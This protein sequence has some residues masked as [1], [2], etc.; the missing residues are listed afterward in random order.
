[1]VVPP[2]QPKPHA[3]QLVASPGYF[4][5]I[6]IPLL[7]GRAFTEAD[8]PHSEPVA[9]VNDLVVQTYWPG[10]NPIGK[11][12]RGWQS[13]DPWRRVVGVVR[14]IR[15]EGPEDNPEN[16][17]Y[18]PYRQI[19]WSTM[20]LVLRTH[21]PP[22]SVALDVRAA[23]QSIDPDVPA[24]EIRSM[25]DRLER[26][27]AMERIAPLLMTVFSAMAALL[28]V[29]G[30][31][32]V[33]GYWVSQRG[34]ELGIRSAVGAQRGELRWLVVRQGGALALIGLLAGLAVS[35][36]LM[37]LMRGT[38]YGVNEHDWSV[39]T[40]AVALTAAGALLAC[41]APAE[42]AARIEPAAA[43]REE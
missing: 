41:W 3:H 19:N 11:R 9:I 6:G 7:A 4:A 27:L 31:F 21:V 35:L 5:A 32:G 18:V 16:Q 33:I 34:K 13:N 39:Y 15:H 30:L 17:I 25:K 14:R 28:A 36:P 29:L 38:V 23:M 42:R 20:F 2:G 43:L 10:Q 37:R 24:F 12:V 8:G 1:L 40:A 22:D 26:E